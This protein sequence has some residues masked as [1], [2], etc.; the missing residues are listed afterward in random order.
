MGAGKIFIAID[1][2]DAQGAAWRYIHSVIPSTATTVIE[3]ES[4][5][6]SCPDSKA[7]ISA[8]EIELDHRPKKKAQNLL[9][10]VIT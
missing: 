8:L 9:K 3:N 4:I 7:A 6:M 5:E 1:F 2:A 10:A